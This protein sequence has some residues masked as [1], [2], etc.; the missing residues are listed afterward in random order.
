MNVFDYLIYLGESIM[1]QEDHNEPSGERK[2][3]EG[4]KGMKQMSPKTPNTPGLKGG[5]LDASK[6]I[7]QQ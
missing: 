2:K 3:Y 5:G 1:M 4:I 6:K 7:K